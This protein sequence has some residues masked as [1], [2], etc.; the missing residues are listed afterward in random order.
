MVG[1]SRGIGRAV[2]ELLARLGAGV[3]ISGREPDAVRD[4]T[5]AVI[6]AAVARPAS[7]A[8]RTTKTRQMHWSIGA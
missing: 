5:E 8:R 6:S 3:V 4:A 7:P 2:A 1:G